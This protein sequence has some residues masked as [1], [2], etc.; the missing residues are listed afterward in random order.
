MTVPIRT[1]RSARNSYA[2]LDRT[3]SRLST[4]S[5]NSSRENAFMNHQRKV[6]K[7]KYLV[8]VIGLNN[9]HWSI[10]VYSRCSRTALIASLAVLAFLI[11]SAIVLAIVLPI[12]LTRGNSSTTSTAIYTIFDQHWFPFGFLGVTT[13]ST[14]TVTTTTTTRK[15]Y[16]SGIRW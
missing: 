9:V 11:I 7:M 5:H 16:L 15:S 1:N 8:L 3:P 10:A 6:P 14:T 12:V 2:N 13:T 4:K